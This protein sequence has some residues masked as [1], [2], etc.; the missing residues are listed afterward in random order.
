NDLGGDVVEV[1]GA[2]GRPAPDSYKVSVAYR[3]GYAASGTLTV[4]GGDES[5]GR[6]CG[7][8]L[9]QRV[10]RA[11]FDL[12]HSYIECLGAGDCVPGTPHFFDHPVEVVLRVAVR[13]S[14]K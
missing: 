11:G 1:R 2:K 10:R 6:Q 3:D 13:D 14:R 5:K 9:L 8:I 4:F 12:E 7:E